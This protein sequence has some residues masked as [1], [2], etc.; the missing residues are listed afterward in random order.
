MP[1]ENRRESSCFLDYQIG[2][3]IFEEILRLPDNYH[4]AEP[5]NRRRFNL[6]MND[7][8]FDRYGRVAVVKKEYRPQEYF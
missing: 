6:N 2:D 1:T 8:T 7:L 5:D 3:V 4:K